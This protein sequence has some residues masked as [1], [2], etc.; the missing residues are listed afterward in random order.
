MIDNQKNY[1]SQE[2]VKPKRP[3][4]LI[5]FLISTIVYGVSYHGI[6]P[7]IFLLFGAGFGLLIA[8]IVFFS[9]Y[10]RRFFYTLLFGI[11]TCSSVYW[12]LLLDS[13]HNEGS[14]AGSV[15]GLVVYL[16]G[17]VFL[18]FYSRFKG[19]TLKSKILMTMLF[20][21]AGLG[22]YHFYDIKAT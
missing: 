7:W 3:F 8:Q 9:I 5:F 12:M 21:V 19:Q 20:I 14:G 11:F 15:M 17:S 2:D 13:H 6:G 18:L 4:S 22:I 10:T 1:I 16:L